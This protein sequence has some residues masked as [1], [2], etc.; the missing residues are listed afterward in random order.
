M[1]PRVLFESFIYPVNVCPG[2]GR[3]TQSVLWVI[4]GVEPRALPWLPS[5]LR[6]EGE[7]VA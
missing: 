1:L 6:F 4:N 5:P 3:S 7:K 2:A